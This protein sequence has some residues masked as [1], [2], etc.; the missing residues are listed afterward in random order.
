[1]TTRPGARNCGRQA[2]LATDNLYI[3]ALCTLELTVSKCNNIVYDIHAAAESR[4]TASELSSLSPVLTVWTVYWLSPLLCRHVRQPD[5]RLPSTARDWPCRGH[6]IV[7]AEDFP[8]LSRRMTSQ[9]G[10][11]PINK[12][13]LFEGLNVLMWTRFLGITSYTVENYILNV[14]T[15]KPE[16]RWISTRYTYE[17][18]TWAL[19]LNPMYLMTEPM[20][21]SMC[22]WATLNY[23]WQS[24]L[25]TLCQNLM[26]NTTS[27][28]WSWMT[29]LNYYTEL[30]N[31]YTEI[32]CWIFRIEI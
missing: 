10:I 30:L 31:N 11:S 3:Q 2:S 5:A 15:L 17:L 13:Q 25:N 29:P 20:R 22:Q 1:M 28:E 14:Y 18:H 6:V 24:H 32:V 26:R 9:L 4:C 16:S 19:Y 23:T 12:N 27:C 8:C 7:V 21:I